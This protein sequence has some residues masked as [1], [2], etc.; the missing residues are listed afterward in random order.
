MVQPKGIALLEPGTWL[1]ALF[2]ST[3]WNVIP[4]NSGVVTERTKVE[5]FARPGSAEGC[6]AASSCPLHLI[7]LVEHTFESLSRLPRHATPCITQAEC[8]CRRRDACDHGRP[9]RRG[10]GLPELRDGRGTAAGPGG[11]PSGGGSPDEGARA[12][13]EPLAV[14]APAQ[15]AV[16]ARDDHRT[17]VAAQGILELGGERQR[18]VVR[19]LVEEEHVW[20]FGDDQREREAP[21]LAEGERADGSV[22]VPRRDE[23]E[24][25]ERQGV[26]TPLPQR[27]L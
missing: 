25:R 23:P 16:V 12:Q 8:G 26:R 17:R 20:R 9:R 10:I 11:A 1:S 3:S 4:A 14:P 22:E 24:P 19:R 15:P 5:S 7:P 18:Q 6:S 13:L 2:A 21:L 27:P